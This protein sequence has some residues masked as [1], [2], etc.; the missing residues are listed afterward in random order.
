MNLYTELVE[1][2]KEYGKTVDDIEFVC[3]EDF[4][5]D[6]QEFLKLAKRTNYDSGFGA[7][8]IACDL[9]VVGKDWW[10][11]RHEYDGSEWFEFKQMPVKPNES[12]PIRTLCSGTWCT[13]KLMNCRN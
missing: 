6:I 5:V 9:M 4:Y 12:K 10:L 3:G 1:K 2:L 7:Q 13:L 11:E 8:E